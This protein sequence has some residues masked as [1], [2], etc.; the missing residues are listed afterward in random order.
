MLKDVFT[1]E[2]P[3]AIIAVEARSMRWCVAEMLLKG[4]FAVEAPVA[5]IAV[6]DWNMSRRIAEVL[7]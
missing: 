4:V 7:V 5:V 1:A 2:A 6:E 3:V